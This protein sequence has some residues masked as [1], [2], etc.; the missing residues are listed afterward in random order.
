MSQTLTEAQTAALDLLGF[1]PAVSTGGGT[2]SPA[3][4][5]ATCRA[6]GVACMIVG[7]VPDSEQPTSRHKAWHGT[8][9]RR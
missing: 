2:F 1:D 9:V 5:F 6:C 8:E 4:Y 3:V 7:G